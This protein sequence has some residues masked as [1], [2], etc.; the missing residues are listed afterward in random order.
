MRLWEAFMLH[1]IENYPIGTAVITPS[2]RRGTV[3]KHLA[4]ESKLDPF[5]R[6]VVRFDGGDKRDVVT[7][8]PHQLR[9][10]PPARPGRVGTSGQAGFEFA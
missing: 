8:Q 1:D 9:L 2:G 7:L 4:G 6:L 3:I 5:D 10:L